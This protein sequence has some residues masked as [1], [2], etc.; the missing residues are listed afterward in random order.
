MANLIITGTNGIFP[1]DIFSTPCAFD[2]PRIYRLKLRILSLFVYHYVKRIY[3]R[4]R[5]NDSAHFARSDSIL[6]A[7]ASRSTS[8]TLFLSSRIMLAV[9]VPSR[10]SISVAETFSPFLQPPRRSR[11][12]P[13]PRP[14]S[15]RETGFHAGET[16]IAFAD[17]NSAAVAV[18]RGD[19]MQLLQGSETDGSAPSC[20]S[21]RLAAGA[22]GSVS[23]PPSRGEIICARPS[24]FECCIGR[25]YRSRC[26]HYYR[27]ASHYSLK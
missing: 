24:T 21:L 6:V 13:I 16:L 10:R 4:N 15:E 23:R 11:A 19:P 18:S 14:D 27:Y 12:R 22:R 8:F 26:S 5:E 9:L 1:A 25:C 17:A 20:I 3:L 2:L 7:Y